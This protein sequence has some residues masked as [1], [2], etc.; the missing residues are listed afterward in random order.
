MHN[1]TLSPIE[2]KILTDSIAK[3][4]TT[5]ILNTNKNEKQPEKLL[6]I[7]SQLKTIFQYLQ[8]HIATASM[9]AEAT[10]VPQKN[11]CRYKRDLE[12]AGRLWEIEKGK[13]KITGFEAWYLTTNPD[14][15]P[16]SNQLSLF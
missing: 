4:I 10:G 6:T 11:I 3:K 16:K 13:C 1:V 15:S 8:H 14:Y 7:E 5:N 12:K 2:L 9:I